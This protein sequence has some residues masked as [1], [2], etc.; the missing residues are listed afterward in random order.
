MLAFITALA[1]MQLMARHRNGDLHDA[2]WLASV[3]RRR[4]GPSAVVH[5]PTF[6]ATR[7]A[8]AGGGRLASIGTSY[9][10]WMV[11]L[12]IFGLSAL[13]TIVIELAVPSWL[14]S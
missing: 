1:S 4:G 13:A 7:D 11:A 8:H 9:V 10:W 2:H 5:G 12:A 14:G 6:K 3:E